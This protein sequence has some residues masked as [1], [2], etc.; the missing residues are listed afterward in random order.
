MW[1]EPTQDGG[2]GEGGG[3]RHGH[4]AQRGMD[5]SKC[6]AFWDRPWGQLGRLLCCSSRGRLAE[7]TSGSPMRKN[8]R[9]FVTGIVLSRLWGWLSGRSSAV[10]VTRPSRPGFAPRLTTTAAADGDDDDDGREGILYMARQ[11]GLGSNSSE[12]RLMLLAVDLDAG[13]LRGYCTVSHILICSLSSIRNGVC[14]AT[15]FVQDALR[16]S[17]VSILLPSFHRSS[18]SSS[19]SSSASLSQSLLLDLHPHADVFGRRFG[20][21]RLGSPLPWFCCIVSVRL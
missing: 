18:S 13:Q 4:A 5:G 14:C 16:L 2:G 19:S 21:E 12:A 7:E 8:R 3:S 15:K 17:R 6:R 20:L 10:R 11:E 1:P 9:L